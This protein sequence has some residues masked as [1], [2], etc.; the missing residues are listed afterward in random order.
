MKL[1]VPHLPTTV[2]SK[3]GRFRFAAIRRSPG[4]LA[5]LLAVTLA[6]SPG[7]RADVSAPSTGVLR[8]TLKNGLRVVIVQND[9]APVVSVEVNYLAGSDEAPDGFPGMAHAQ[10]HMMFRGSAGLTGDQL[11]YLNAVLG[12]MANAAT[13]QS[14]TQYSNTVPARDLGLA[15]RI[16]SIRM[17]GVSDSE[18]SWVKERGAIEQEVARDLSE[19]EYVLYT[20]LLETLFEGTPYAHDALGTHASFEKTTGAMLKAYYDRWYAPNN[21]ILVIAGDVQP[22]AVLDQVKALFGD[23]PGKKLPARPEVRLARPQSRTIRGQTDKASGLVL[24]AFRVPGSDSPDHAAVSLLADVLGSQRGDL[25]ALAADGKA[26]TTD[27]QVDLLPKA[28]LAYVVA[29]F[30]KGQDPSI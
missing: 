10:E 11:A 13:Q 7:A 1:K 8:A 21:A 15:L 14:V 9:L 4:V 30:P 16:E 5:A 25:Y 29:E 2:G 19:P 24:T 17:R 12:G 3:P 6:M 22:K 18:E 20:K 26:L 27:A 23:I 28:G